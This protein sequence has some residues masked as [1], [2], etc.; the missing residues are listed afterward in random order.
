MNGQLM[1]QHCRYLNLL[2]II[3]NIILL[4]I[5]KLLSIEIILGILIFYYEIKTFK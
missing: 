4:Y 1:K 5:G 3:L 2:T